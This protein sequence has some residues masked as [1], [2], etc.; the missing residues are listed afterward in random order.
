MDTM[1]KTCDFSEEKNPGKALIQTL[2]YKQSLVRCRPVIVSGPDIQRHIRDAKLIAKG[3]TS[4]TIVEKDWEVYRKIQNNFDYR[5]FPNVCVLNKDIL[6]VPLSAFVDADLTGTFSSLLK[7]FTSIYLEMRDLVVAE[8]KHLIMT[9]SQREAGTPSL[10]CILKY[11]CNQA[12]IPK[13]AKISLP[14]KN[15]QKFQGAYMLAYPEYTDQYGYNFNTHVVSYS[16][17]TGPMCS[18][19]LQWSR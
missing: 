5:E 7:T 8:R 16:I 1:Y 12:E 3:T 14:I 4:I 6:D 10:E 17:G 18:I 19:S 13:P 15:L 11:F 9:F 2:L